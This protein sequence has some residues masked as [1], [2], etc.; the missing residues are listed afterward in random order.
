MTPSSVAVVTIEVMLFAGVIALLISS[1]R[2]LARILRKAPGYLDA[3]NQNRLGD[4]M[5]VVCGVAL[6][7]WMVSS[8]FAGWMWLDYLFA[9]LV[10]LAVILS[11]ITT[12]L[13]NRALDRSETVEGQRS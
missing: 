6:L 12:T 7:A 4:A 3:A 2:Y 5:V 11:I 13:I 9:G 10:V 1:G 8:K